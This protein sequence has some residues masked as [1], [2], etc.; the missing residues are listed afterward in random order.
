[1]GS[2]NYSKTSSMKST[3]SSSSPKSTK[4]LHYDMLKEMLLANN[5]NYIS[6]KGNSRYLHS[7]S[8]TQTDSDLTQSTRYMS[9]SDDDDDDVDFSLD[10]SSH[11]IPPE[12]EQ[13][14]QQQEILVSILRRTVKL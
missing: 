4:R 2:L 14:Q 6:S 11:L 10:Q 7:N 3:C 8:L 12:E 5:Y 13:Q 9:E 1:M